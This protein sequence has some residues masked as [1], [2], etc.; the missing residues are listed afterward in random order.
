MEEKWTRVVIHDPHG[1]TVAD[2]PLSPEGATEQVSE[3]NADQEAHPYLQEQIE[4]AEAAAK[5]YADG[6]V[7]E[8]D[9]SQAAHQDIREALQGQRTQIG[10]RITDLVIVKRDGT[11]ESKAKADSQGNKIAVL[12][13]ADLGKV[14]GIVVNDSEEDEP[15]DQDGKVHLTIPQNVTDLE[16]AD[17]YATKEYT[18]ARTIGNV[19][20]TVEVGGETKTATVTKDGSDVH[21][22]FP[23]LQGQQGVRGNGITSI[24]QTTVATEDGG[25][26]IVNIK[27]TD[28]PQG[29][30]IEINNGS[31]GRPGA[32]RQPVEA[33]DVIIA[34]G[35][36]NNEEQVMSQKA[37]TEALVAKQN[38]ITNSSEDAADFCIADGNGNVIMSLK[39]GHVKTKNFDSSKPADVA[40]KD[41][42]GVDDSVFYIA[43]SEGNVVAK[44]ADGHVKTKNFDSSEISTKKRIK[45]LCFGN[46]FTVDAMAYVPYIVRNAAPGIDLTIGIGYIGGCPLAQHVANL[47]GESQTVDG[48]TY[49]P[50]NYTY[51]KVTIGNWGEIGNKSAAQMIADEDWDIVTLQQNGEASHKSWSTYYAPFIYKA[52]KALFDTIGK[53]VKLGWFLTHASYSGTASVL[54]ERYGGI[55]ANAEKVAAETPFEIVFPYGT[56][57]QN[58]RSTTLASVGDGG[59]LM[60]SD[61]IH[62]Q[63]GLPCLCA[64]YAC[65]LKILE[66]AGEESCS[67]LSEQTRP[68]ST[69]VTAKSIPQQNGTSIGVTDDNVYAA[70]VAA[71]M[72]IKKPFEVTDCTNF[73][74]S[75]Q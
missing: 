1:N 15:I 17:D 18:D 69:W 6:K 55:T 72:A 19:T 67:I 56:A 38:V 51:F 75:N 74:T 53:A 30:N 34:H 61:N 8:H 45:I 50:T 47:T 54:T 21:I 44:F 60:Y 23:D 5:T 68:D 27:T 26:N 71:I 64:A 66:M 9:A 73:V 7:S 65:A 16:D 48:T 41:S 52:C 10:N 63:E 20:A 12:N 14:A 4:D 46:S 28:N 62:L 40:S 24:T 25:K 36:G 31:T 13:E 57:I 11:E 35:T 49:S 3:H 59:N 32:D 58:L 37:T 42:A 22:D 70:Q 43:D 2:R 29:V 33:G 39:D